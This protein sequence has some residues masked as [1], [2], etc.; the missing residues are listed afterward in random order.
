MFGREQEEGAAIAGAAV[1]VSWS[2]RSR[3]SAFHDGMLE[4]Y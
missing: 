4:P 2:A 3:E 1:V